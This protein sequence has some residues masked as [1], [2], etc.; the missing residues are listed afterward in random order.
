MILQPLQ[1]G[2]EQPCRRQQN[3]R[4]SRLN[5][6][7][8][9]PWER[10]FASSRATAPVKRFDWVYSGGHPRGADAER[11]SRQQRNNEGEQQDWL[12]R[13]RAARHAREAGESWKCEMENPAR[14][15]ECNP[16]ALRPVKAREPS[17]F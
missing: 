8:C 2:R 10:A 15:R 13:R 16:H 3:K 17:T 12:G 4:E 5:H 9:F 6:D 11:N 7:E 1:S 14:T